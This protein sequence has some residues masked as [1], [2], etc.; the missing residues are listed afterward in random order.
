M[1]QYIVDTKFAAKSLLEV[2][3]EEENQ[4]EILK[5]E[6]VKLK[7]VWDVLDW[8]FST[9]DLNEDY[10]EYQVQYKF[11]QREK[12]AE[13]N[14]LKDKKVE[15]RKLSESML[16]KKHS[17]NSLSMS[18][19]Q[20]AKQGISTVHGHPK[21]CV[22]GRSISSETLKNVILQGRNQSIHCEEGNPH[23][24]V[25][26]CFANL[27][28]DFGVNFDLTI[29]KTENRARQIIELLGWS[30]YETYE[31]DMVQLLG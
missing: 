31:S 11:V 5:K 19:L 1:N 17:I 10:S 8:D 22:D 25:I 24:P 3:H 12:F 30:S 23:Q 21:K 13:E 20:I 7:K 18:L 9:A 28:K 26:D 14:D 27:T 29:N 16:T 4:F 6:Y 2:I 15:L